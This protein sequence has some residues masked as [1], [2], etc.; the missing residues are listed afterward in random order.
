MVLRELR[1]NHAL[2]FRPVGFIDD[3]RSKHRTQIYGV[4]VL[5]GRDAL[6]AAVA[7]GAISRVII[8]SSKIPAAVVREIQSTCEEAGVSLMRAS[9]RLE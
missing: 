4:P 5:G 7:E 6:P 9:L 3:D 2:G 8:S 1:N